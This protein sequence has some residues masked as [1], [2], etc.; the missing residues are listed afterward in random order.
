V[1]LRQVAVTLLAGLG[2]VAVGFFYGH[3]SA[4]GID[5]GSDADPLVSKSFVDQQ[6]TTWQAKVDQLQAKTDQLQAKVDQLQAKVDLQAGGA[7]KGAAA[8]F[9]VVQL[10]KGAALIGESGTEIVLRAGQATAIVSPK[11]GVL[12]ATAGLDLA[13]DAAVV[14]NHMLVIPVSDGRGLSAKTDAILIVKGPFT[15]R[16]AGQ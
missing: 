9:G 7:D 16:P 15:I 10:P 11:G 5:P 4:S 12:D 2:L 14:K 1:N 6:M 13:P 3:V 8:T